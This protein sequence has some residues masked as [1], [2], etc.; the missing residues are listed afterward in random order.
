[1]RWRRYVFSLCPHALIRLLTSVRLLSSRRRSVHGT[2]APRAP[3]PVW[4]SQFRQDC[5]TKDILNQRRITTGYRLPTAMVST[6]DGDNMVIVNSTTFFHRKRMLLMGTATLFAREDH[7]YFHAHYHNWYVMR[8]HLGFD[9]G[10]L[11]STDDPYVHYGKYHHHSMNDVERNP[12]KQLSDPNLDFTAALGMLE[13]RRLDGLGF[14]S[15]RFL[16]VI[17]N[18][19]VIYLKSDDIGASSETDVESTGSDLLALLQ[20]G[21]ENHAKYWLTEG[22]R[23]E[24]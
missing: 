20:K 16:A 17:D 4:D 24:L 2:S 5:V 18:G 19:E 7:N 21:S 1:M 3:K 9:G 11:M 6:F 23:D 22:P 14:R 12:F 10:V 15:R 13:D 8:K